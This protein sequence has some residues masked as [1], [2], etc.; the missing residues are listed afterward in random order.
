[1]KDFLIG[2]FTHHV[3]TKIVSLLLAVV[4]FVFVQQSISE[5]RRIE[6]LVVEF[7]LSAELDKTWVLLDKEVV[8]TD[9]TVRGLRETLAREMSALRSKEGF[10]IKKIID[11]DFIS[12]YKP[13]NGVVI[14]AALCRAEG[15]PWELGKDF[16]LR[17]EDAPTLQLF[18]RVNRTLRPA[19]SPEMTKLLDLP[20]DFKFVRTGDIE[21]QEPLTIS[22]SGP[23]AALPS[24]APDAVLDLFVNIEPLEEELAA[25]ESESEAR[26]LRYVV[27]SI[28]WKRSGFDTGLLDHVRAESPAASTQY[29]HLELTYTVPVEMRREKLEKLAI[30]LRFTT[31]ATH[32]QWDQLVA[33]EFRY[34]GATG[35]SVPKPPV[36]GKFQQV[37]IDLEVIP[38][39]KGRKDELEK[40]LA[41]EIDFTAAIE[42]SGRI[43]APIFLRATRDAPARLLSEVR[44]AHGDTNEP[45][46]F[47]FQK[48]KQ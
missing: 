38:L 4:L 1:M 32:I 17:I 44:L 47:L 34:I 16:E 35:L 46:N 3:V 15:I 30:P 20:A 23:T 18:G 41:L 26:G 13:Q 5:T 43:E 9:I 21:F 31:D 33:K 42:D 40:F 12:K 19:L 10:R 14:N 11:E 24:A 48:N 29:L 8:L 37:T 36:D 6:R 45:E 2:L 27:D 28:D 39:W 7:E 22:V 25:V